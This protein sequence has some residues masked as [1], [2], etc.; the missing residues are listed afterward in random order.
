MP[1]ARGDCACGFRIG[2]KGLL[3]TQAAT[4]ASAR[5]VVWC[6]A[7][8]WGQRRT[9][10]GGLTTLSQV[11]TLSATVATHGAMTAETAPPPTAVRIGVPGVADS[12]SA[13]ALRRSGP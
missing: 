11:I 2:I 9:R 7:N 10:P 8:G 5:A 6:P 3:R 4:D 1:R 13:A 12:A